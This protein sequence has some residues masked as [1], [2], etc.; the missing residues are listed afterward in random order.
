MSIG[1]GEYGL[2]RQPEVGVIE[3]VE[4][5][6]AELEVLT[7]RQPRV[8]HQSE[9]QCGKGRTLHSVPAQVSEGA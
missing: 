2:E 1:V 6:G 3:E 8:F 5:F 9:V 4:K 7:L